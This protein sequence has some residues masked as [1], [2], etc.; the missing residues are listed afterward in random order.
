MSDDDEQDARVFSVDCRYEQLAR[1]PGGVPRDEAI[2]RA[3]AVIEEEI[4]PGFG[5]WLDQELTELGELIRN[6]STDGSG[7]DPWTE[8][9]Y[10]QCRRIRDVGTT[11]GFDLITFVA[12]NLCEIFEAVKSGAE[13]RADLV[14]CHIQALLFARQERY[15][16]LHPEQLPELSS[17]LRRVVEYVPRE[18]APK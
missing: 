5:A 7:H 8:A 10:V 4:K 12:N 1:R 16:N 2:A 3:R 18:H 11:M 17:G 6:G 13:Y 14:D 9:A 15:R